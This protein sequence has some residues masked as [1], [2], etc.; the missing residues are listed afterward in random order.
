[1]SIGIK[2][3]LTTHGTYWNEAG[4]ITEIMNRAD[5]FPLECFECAAA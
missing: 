3:A 1:M 4:E 5:I 2:E